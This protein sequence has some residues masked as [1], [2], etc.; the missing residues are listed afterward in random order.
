MA[1]PGQKMQIG[2]FEDKAL[3]ENVFKVGVTLV[4]GKKPLCSKG[5]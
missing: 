4:T 2:T 1:E 3:P 5:F